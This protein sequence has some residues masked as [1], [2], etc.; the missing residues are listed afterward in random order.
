[1]FSCSGKNTNKDLTTPKTSKKNTRHS[2][3]FE[4][5]HCR[6]ARWLK[7][8]HHHHRRH[9][10][11]KP[12]KIYSAV[13]SKRHCCDAL[14]NKSSGQ[15]SS[16]LTATFA[17]LHF[18]PPPRHA[19]HISRCGGPCQV[20]IVRACVPAPPR[21]WNLIPILNQDRPGHTEQII[22]TFIGP[23]GRIGN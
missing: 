22:N 5:A 10:A 4:I 14:G 16:K 3:Y 23:W 15:G 6:A 2:C 11:E 8:I 9:H 17:L 1:M 21:P 20:R 13:P 18:P 7:Q 12:P 19:V